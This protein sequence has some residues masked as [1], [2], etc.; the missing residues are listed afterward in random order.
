MKSAKLL[1]TAVLEG[2]DVHNLFDMSL[3]NKLGLV[4][5]SFQTPYGFGV[6]VP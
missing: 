5:A 3:M 2:G 6:L 4:V 1:A